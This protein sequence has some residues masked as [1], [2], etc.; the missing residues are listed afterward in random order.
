VP[1]KQQNAIALVAQVNNLEDW[2]NSLREALPDETL[3][4]YPDVPDPAAVKIALVAK[5]PTGALAIFPNLE[6]ICSLWA[7]VDK[8]LADSTL[9]PMPVLT[10][11]IDPRLTSAMTE[12]VLTHVLLAHRQ[13]PAYLRQE[14]RHEWRQLRQPHAWERRVGILGL[15]ILGQAAA[16]ALRQIGFPVAGWSRARTP[17]VEGVTVYTGDDGLNEILAQSDI[18]V[19]LLPHTPQTEGLL[20]AERLAQLPAGAVVINV[21]RGAVIVEEDLMAALDKGHLEAAILD[22]FAVEPLPPTH[23]FWAH[24]RVIVLPHVASETD[25]RSAAFVVAETIRRY[26]AGEPLPERVDRA[27][28]Y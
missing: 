18:L 24:E 27:A 15:G 13:I 14:K 23:S 20:N 4:I 8:L 1:Q 9:P 3:W 26:R 2:K 6:L 17:Q 22:V 11:L 28:G 21:G 10:R 12:T 16:K 5:P 19:S 25:P 7:G